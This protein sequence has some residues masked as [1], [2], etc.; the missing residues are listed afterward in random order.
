MSLFSKADLP[1]SDGLATAPRDSLSVI[2]V[3]VKVVGDIH[4]AGVLKIEGHLQG[5]VRAARQLL[6]GR[7]GVVH[8]N[9]DA[10]EVVLG[11]AVRGNIASTGRVE[12]QN[13][14]TVD[15]D[16]RSASIVVAEGGTINGSV[17]TTGRTDGERGSAR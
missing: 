13:A 17:Q 10:D 9:I 16:I 5:S 6:L 1:A 12:I 14:A 3:G 7:N 4:D 8:G 2:G 15:G 11:G